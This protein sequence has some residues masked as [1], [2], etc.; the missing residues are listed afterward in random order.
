MTMTTAWPTVT[1]DAIDM[2]RSAGQLL[3]ELGDERAG[4]L[5]AALEYRLRVDED[6]SDEDGPD[7]DD[8]TEPENRSRVG[9]VLG[10]VREEIAGVGWR[11]FVAYRRQRLT[12]RVVYLV[13][14]RWPLTVRVDPP[15][16]MVANGYPL[17]RIDL[18]RGI[19]PLILA[20]WRQRI[21]TA[22]SCAGHRRRPAFVTVP[23]DHARQLVEFCWTHDIPAALENAVHGVSVRLPSARAVS[24]LVAALD[25][26]EQHFHP[27]EGGQ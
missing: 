5:L 7:E 6:R 13:R 27:G 2:D 25:L 21:P 19:R 20:L 23:A 16:F 18:D 12:G 1:V 22:W 15:A 3:D 9:L 8:T 24:A 4:D 10:D 17:D 26:T 11:D 14:R